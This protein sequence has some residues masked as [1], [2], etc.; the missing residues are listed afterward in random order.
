MGKRP[1]S[2][3]PSA[4]ERGDTSAPAMGIS[5][6]TIHVD[7]PTPTLELL[8]QLK[9]DDSLYVRKS[10]ANHLNDHLKEHPD[11]VLD[12]LERWDELMRLMK[13]AGLSVMPCG[14]C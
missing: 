3:Y 2:P 1:Q 14:I 12:I 4:G 9:N 8:E 13:H 11:L 7:D 5:F 10:V 6:A